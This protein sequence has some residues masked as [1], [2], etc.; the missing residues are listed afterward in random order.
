[1]ECPNCG[2]A[3]IDRYCPRCGQAR[4]RE[5]DY[6]LGSHFADFFEQLTSLDG[7][8][9]RTALTLVRSP[10]LLTADHLAGRRA[11]YVRPLQFFLIVNV[12][13]FFAAPRVPIFT[14]SLAN[15]AS[16]A[17]P[18]PALVRSLVARAVPR[19][20]SAARAVYARAFDDRVETQRKSLILLFA[21]A[22]ALILWII[23]SGS[24]PDKQR[25]ARSRTPRRYGEHLVFALHLLAF[26]WLVF[27]GWGAL[28][29]MLSG[30]TFE[31]TRGQVLQAVI[32]LYMLIIPAYSFLAARRVYELSI[33]RALG[34]T[35]VV[36]IAF[37]GLLFVYRSVLF[38]TTYYTL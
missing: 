3:P 14:Y 29:A 8:V 20:D 11:R 5:D 1:M 15:Y 6:S 2:F 21:P 25:E 34:L 12:L 7:K 10:G 4:P 33:T 19:G 28:A 30:Q 18:S 26:V 24:H 31:G 16:A 9:P 32:T 13:L 38:F 36:S 37:I 17:P 22:L 35:M 27:V 23:F